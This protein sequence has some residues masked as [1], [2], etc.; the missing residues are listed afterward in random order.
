MGR[1]DHKMLNHAIYKADLDSIHEILP[2]IARKAP[3]IEPAVRITSL[4]CCIG[5]YWSQVDLTEA[6]DPRKGTLPPHLV[7]TEEETPTREVSA[8]KGLDLVMSG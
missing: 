5:S 6:R 2:S 7:R 1:F 8:I 4:E 3:R